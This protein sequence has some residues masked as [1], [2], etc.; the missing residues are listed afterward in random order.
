MEENIV[1][2]AQGRLPGEETLLVEFYTDEIPVWHDVIPNQIVGYRQEELVK[3][4]RPG[5]L[6]QVFVDVVDARHI[7]RFPLEYAAFKNGQKFEVVGT[8]LE[9]IAGITSA[10]IKTLKQA[11]ITT[12]EA[13]SKASDS[14]LQRYSMTSY[15]YKAIETLARV[16]KEDVEE[17]LAQRDAEIAELRAQ[18]AQ[19]LSATKTKPAKE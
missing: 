9:R 4:Q 2:N 16:E 3:I 18:M 12:V 5:V 8:P 11:G 19:L 6:T 15:K 17:A 1:R 7:D 10:H 13:L 14:S